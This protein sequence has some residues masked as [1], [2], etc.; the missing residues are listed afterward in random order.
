M[1]KVKN[2]RNDEKR[3]IMMK[4]GLS[5]GKIKEINSGFFFMKMGKCRKT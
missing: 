3:S 5:K 1:E 4:K 2:V